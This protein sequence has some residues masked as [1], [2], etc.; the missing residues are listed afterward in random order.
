L[1]VKLAHVTIPELQREVLAR[2]IVAQISG[3]S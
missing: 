1:D 2:G 3:D